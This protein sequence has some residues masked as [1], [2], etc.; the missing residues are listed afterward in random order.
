MVLIITSLLLLIAI[1][2]AVVILVKQ[3]ISATAEVRPTALLPFGT[4]ITWHWARTWYQ[5]MFVGYEPSHARTR[6][7][8]PRVYSTALP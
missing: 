8:V 3:E 7:G 2:I 1:I 6:S 5:A 4:R